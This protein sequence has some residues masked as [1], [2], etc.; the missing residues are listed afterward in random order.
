M[1]ALRLLLIAMLVASTPAGA[2]V[3]KWTDAQGRV[4]Y[5]DNPPP[6]VKAQQVKVK[7]NSIQ[8]PAVVSTVRD[9]PAAKAKEKSPH[10]YRCLVRLL[11]EGE[12]PPRNQGSALRRGGRGGF[13][14]RPQRIYPA[15]RAR[16]PGHSGGE[17]AHGRVR[18][19]RAGRDAG[20]GWLVT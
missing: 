12:G 3:Y 19:Q 6:E 15:W 14:T 2:G 13:G 18:C 20:G 8:G 4:H 7:I 11:Q 17:P 9:T 16:C 5:S 10:L 1:I